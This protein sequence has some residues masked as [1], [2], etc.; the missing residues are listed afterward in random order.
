MTPLFRADQ[1]GSLIRPAFLLEERGSLGFY[2]SKL[3]EDQAAATSA[4]IKYAVQEQL[5][6]GVR[7]ITSGEYERTIFFSG[8][9]ENLQGMTVRDDLRIPQDFRPNLPTFIGLA[10]M[11]YN[12]FSAVPATG[13]IMFTDS[14]YLPAWEMIKKAVPQE[15]W[16]DCKMSIPSI[17]WQHMYLANGTAFALGVYASDKD[18]FLDLAA[19][20]R[21]EIQALYDAGLRSIQ[22]DD[23]NLT[24][25]VTKGFREG[26]RGDGIDP[27]ALL[28]LY[29]WAHNQVLRDL[30]P[31]LHVG[32]HLCRGNM[33]GQPSFAKGSYERIAAKVFPK[34]NYHTFY[35]EFDDPR[36]SGHFDP[37]RFV[38]QG[39]NVVLGLVSTKVADLENKEALIKRVYE[40]AEVMAKAQRRDVS[41]VLADSLA[42]SPQCGF[43]SFS[44]NQGVT[45]EDRM[46]KKLVLVR[47]VARS[48][49]KDAV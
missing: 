12:H 21:S 31:D 6:L 11:G 44:I 39:K 41:E 24:F 14:A 1:I 46:W 25:F 28:D 9:F 2:D 32:I 27:E 47:D 34:L 35:L 37:L 17:S 43:A 30:P 8:L 45:T 15:R 40:A 23:P 4:S 22:V 26:L 20:F 29:I 38:P 3:S 5:K 49:W 36:V 16:K 33:P 19:A 42:V 10:K 7:P 13:K 48:I 18:Y